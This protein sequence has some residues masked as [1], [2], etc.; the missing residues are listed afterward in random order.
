MM[1]DVEF[2]LNPAGIAELA[3][4]AGTAAAAS[5]AAHDVA[6]R[7]PASMNAYVDTYVTD[8]AAAS[9]TVSGPNA[10]GREARAGAI[11]AAATAAGLEYRGRT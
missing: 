9:V 5:G 3:K 11:A 10:A 1:A 7:L 6:S 8:R 2:V 4:S